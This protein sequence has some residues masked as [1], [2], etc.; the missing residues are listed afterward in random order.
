MSEEFL[1]FEDFRLEDPS[2]DGVVI[3]L[4]RN[5]IQ[6]DI[7]ETAPPHSWNEPRRFRLVFKSV[8]EVRAFSTN[9]GGTRDE[10]WELA[11]EGADTSRK[12]EIW[13][14]IKPAFRRE[15]GFTWIA[16]ASGEPQLVT[17]ASDGCYL[18][19]VYAGPREVTEAQHEG[20][21]TVADS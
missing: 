13:V 18:E 20:L 7:S 12:D 11:E 16:H 8:L 5:I 14:R 17:V 10:L 21:L 2:L 6:L 4:G 9:S 19:F 15:P 1:G 3:D